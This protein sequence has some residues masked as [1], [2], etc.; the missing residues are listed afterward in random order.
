MLLRGNRDALFS[1]KR[2]SALQ[3]NEA[4]SSYCE[5]GS[6]MD[7]PEVHRCYVNGVGRAKETPAG[8]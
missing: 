2:S 8:S 5:G 7:I 1:L 3:Y 6:S 4:T